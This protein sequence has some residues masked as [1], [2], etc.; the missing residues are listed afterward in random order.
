MRIQAKWI[1]FLCLFLASSVAGA[2]DF[3]NGLD[4]LDRGD[5]G[6][7]LKEFKPLAEAGNARA[8][9]RLGI[10]YAMGLGLAR[11]Y[12]QAV[13]WLRKSATQGNAHA[14][15]DLGVLY[16][17]GRGVPADPKEAS[18]WFRKAAEQGGGAA[19][20]N[21]AS[22]YEQGRGVP[23]DPV[24]AFAWADAATQFGELRAQRLLDSIA[25]KMTPEQ[26]DQAQQ[27]AKQYRQKYVVPFRTY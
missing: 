7:A 3:A 19:Q 21:L 10:M 11:D 22:L 15:D 26:I 25:R 6:T 1:A 24:E 14:Q 12:R 18:R 5:Y 9:Y 20:F 27:R 4:A 16:D 8:Q 23:M 2:A 17:F 13:N